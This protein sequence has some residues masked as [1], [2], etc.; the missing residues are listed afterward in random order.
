MTLDQHISRHA[1]ASGFVDIHR[2]QDAGSCRLMR[3]KHKV[4]AI[5]RCPRMSV[6]GGKTHTAPSITTSF[7]SVS[8]LRM[9][10]P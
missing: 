1:L 9:A 2:K 8:G 3:L 5:E 4:K 7:H 6:L 10:I